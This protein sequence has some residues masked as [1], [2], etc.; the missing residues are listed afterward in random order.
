MMLHIRR[1]ANAAY[2]IRL[3]IYWRVARRD[4]KGYW[5]IRTPAGYVGPLVGFTTCGSSV[6][7]NTA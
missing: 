7:S 1:P 2:A 4:S 6:N 5:Q 3:A